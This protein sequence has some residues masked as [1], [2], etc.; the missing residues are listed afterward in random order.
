LRAIRDVAY[1]LI[2]RACQFLASLREDD[3]D[4]HGVLLP[5]Q[6]TSNRIFHPFFTTKSQGTGMGLSICR[7]IIE[8]HNGR[9]SLRSAS[10]RGSI[11]QISL[12]AGDF[13]AI[14]LA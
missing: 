5:P 8:A 1:W 9:L 10:D 7:S 6:H 14:A 3:E 11:F 4:S 2:F 13:E 12:P